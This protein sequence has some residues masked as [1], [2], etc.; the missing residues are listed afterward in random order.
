MFPLQLAHP[1]GLEPVTYGLEDR[2]SNPAELRMHYPIQLCRGLEQHRR[3]CDQENI[4]S[5]H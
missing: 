1:T 3:N 4:Q 5:S 2:C